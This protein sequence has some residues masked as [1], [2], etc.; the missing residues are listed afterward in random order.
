VIAGFN[1]YA[2]AD[3][4]FTVRVFAS[5]IVATVAV[6][7]WLWKVGLDRTFPLMPFLCT[8]YALMYGVPVFLLHRYSA[9]EFN[10]A[11][12]GPQ[13][14]AQAVEYAWLGMLL[15]LAGYYGPLH[16]LFAP[17]MPR[18]NL[19]W[20]DIRSVRTAAILFS[21]IG[22][23]VAIIGVRVPVS[24]AQLWGYF[25]NLSL[26]GIAILFILQLIGRLDRRAMLLLWIVI[27][28][29][30]SLAAVARGGVGGAAGFGLLLIVVYAAV[31]HRIPWTLLAAGTLAGLIVRSVETPYRLATWSGPLSDV[32]EV[33]KLEYF[34]ELA[35]RATIGGA[36]RPDAL[37]EAGGA[38]LAVFPLFAE[39]IRDTPSH[40]P[41][42]GGATYYPILFKL[43]P[44]FLYPEK[45]E[46]VTG[47]TFG[48]RYGLID[49]SNLGTSVN[50]PQTVEMYANFGLRGVLIGMFI[51]GLFFRLIAAMFVHPGMGMG[52][53]VAMSVLAGLTWDIESS[54]SMVLGAV[55]WILIFIGAMHLLVCFVESERRWQSLV[56]ATPEGLAEGRK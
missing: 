50:F 28:P 26:V 1:L 7:V 9:G 14:I 3:P 34:G 53:V 36:V 44:R 10:S 54:A 21:I 11:P 13:Y 24:F 5:L 4:D 16:S 45:P 2:P 56:L 35:Y 30:P 20:R 15:I 18:F 33:E 12:I 48:H 31:T 37:I 23:V 47:Q 25:A 38:R 8:L 40:V 32:S 29:A 17:I 42:W 46:E 41:Y 39:V 22:V 6:P 49:A 19:R 51:V 55:P 43:I 27:I 52:G